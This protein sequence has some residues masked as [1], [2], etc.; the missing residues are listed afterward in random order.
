MVKRT[1]KRVIT[2]NSAQLQSKYMNAHGLFLNEYIPLPLLFVR[3]VFS[4][5]PS[6]RL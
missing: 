3:I 4:L 6:L 5:F 1:H 2:N